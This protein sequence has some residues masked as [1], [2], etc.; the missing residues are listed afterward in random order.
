[1]LTLHFCSCLPKLKS[2]KVRKEEG[3]LRFM[4]K[5]SISQVDARRAR[6]VL[7]QSLAKLIDLAREHF[8]F[9]MRDMGSLAK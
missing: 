5:G 3:F 2:S 4:Q 1:M 6:F 8:A 7:K 9:N